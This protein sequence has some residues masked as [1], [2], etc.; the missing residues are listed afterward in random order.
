MNIGIIIIKQGN[1]QKWVRFPPTPVF[2][3]NFIFPQF[4][5]LKTVGIATLK[6][7]NYAQS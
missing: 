6:L 5:G 4:D 2:I 3:H 7:E 1:P